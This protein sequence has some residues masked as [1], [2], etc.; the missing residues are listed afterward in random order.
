MQDALGGK[1]ARMRHRRRTLIG[2]ALVA[3]LLVPASIAWA[4]NPQAYVRL[5]KSGYVSGE[6]MGVSGAFFKSNRQLTLSFEPGGDVTTVKTT[7]NGFFAT[8]ITAP[9]TPGSYTLSAIGYEEDGTVTPGLPARISFEVSP[10][11]QPGQ[12][13]PQ[14]GATQPTPGATQPTPDA[15]PESQQPGSGRFTEPREPR[16]RPFPTPG[17][18]SPRGAPP[19]TRELGDAGRGGAI[20]NTGGDGVMDT[21]DGAVFAGS[22]ASEDRAAVASAGD[23]QVGD[24]AQGRETEGTTGPSERSAAGDVWGGFASADGPS[25]TS[26]ATGPVVNRGTG[27]GLTWGLGLLGLGLA[28][29]V[30]GIAVAEVRRRR[31]TAA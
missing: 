1:A 9:S 13:G 7:N 23:G 8:Q 17:S 2:L 18:G 15:Q 31:A 14:P 6:Q 27:A 25:L 24:T 29:L 16:A 21:P 11:A 4:C 28:V 3:M 10:P 5:D 22:V 26:D 20:G 30:S 12:P 19:R